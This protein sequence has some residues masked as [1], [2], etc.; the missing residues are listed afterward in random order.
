MID[1]NPLRARCGG[2]MT[3]NLLEKTKENQGMR[4]KNLSLFDFSYLTSTMVATGT[5]D[6]VATLCGNIPKRQLLVGF[7]PTT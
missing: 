3:R 4:T 7:K 1:V 5:Q 2:A 6:R